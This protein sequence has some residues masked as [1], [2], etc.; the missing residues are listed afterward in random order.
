MKKIAAI[1][2]LVVL[3]SITAV[4]ADI[5]ELDLFD[6]GC[7]SVYDFDSQYW[8]TDFDLGVTF[9]EISNVYIDW[10]G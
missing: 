1:S 9:I 2:G 4:N 8:T 5:A 6:L 3:L 10:A 7:Q